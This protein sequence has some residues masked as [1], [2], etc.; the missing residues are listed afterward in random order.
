[1]I[2]WVLEAARQV[3]EDIIVV[4]NDPRYAAFGVE[5]VSDEVRGKGP[6]A[7]L[8][9]GLKHSKHDFNLVLSCDVPDIHPELLR[10]LVSQGTDERVTI[11]EAEGRWHPLVAVYNRNIIPE[12]EQSL[13]EDQLKLRNIIFSLAP[14]VLDLSQEMPGFESKWLQNYNFLKDIQESE[15]LSNDQQL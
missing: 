5:V 8:L 3:C 9:S 4:A 1:M 6:L 12:L 13:A 15:Q 2:Q 14:R 7:G 11:T 10:F